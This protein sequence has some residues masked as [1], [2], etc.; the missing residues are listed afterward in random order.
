MKTGTKVDDEIFKK[1]D[2]NQIFGLMNIANIA[3]I[4]NKLVN[5][6]DN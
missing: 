2:D 5:T 6:D 4:A 3:N 1:K